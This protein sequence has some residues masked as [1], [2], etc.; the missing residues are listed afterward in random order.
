M[1]SFFFGGFASH[2]PLRRPAAPKVSLASRSH[3][4]SMDAGL[5]SVTGALY[6]SSA[7]SCSSW[8][9]YKVRGR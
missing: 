7:S 2:A 4:E 5:S 8:A 1:D 3:I 6:D 9:G